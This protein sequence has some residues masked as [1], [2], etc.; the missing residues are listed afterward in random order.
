LINEGLVGDLDTPAPAVL[1]ST[2]IVDGVSYGRGGRSGHTNQ[3]GKWLDE[4]DALSR[5]ITYTRDAA[6]NVIAIIFPDGS[7]IEAEYDA[8]G[9]AISAVK[10]DAEQCAL[11]PGERDPDQQQRFEKSHESRFDQVKTLTTAT[12][13]V[14]TYTY[15]YEL[16]LGQAG[17]LVRI[18]YPPVQD[19]NGDLVTPVVSYTYNS[20]GLRETE[21][22]FYGTVTC[23]TY[24]QGTN[25]EAYGQSGALFAQGVTPVPGLL[26]QVIQ[27]DGGYDYTTIYKDF[28]PATA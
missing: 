3:W 16:G 8:N 2:L 15:D 13:Q 10:M 25:D 21:T 9:H 18:T 4:T 5:T 6:N 7:C 20:L 17:R 28:N 1:T 11:A 12:G 22:D 27:D 23:Y 14:I 26:T 24:T 19:E